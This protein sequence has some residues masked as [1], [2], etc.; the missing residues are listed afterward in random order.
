MWY[1]GFRG[2]VVVVVVVGVASVGELRCAGAV[3]D[4]AKKQPRSGRAN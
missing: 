2:R 1:S 3:N 4:A